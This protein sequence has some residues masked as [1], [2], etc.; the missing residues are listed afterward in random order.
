[1][2]V[3]VDEVV[4][5]R[6]IEAFRTALTRC[7]V[8]KELW[9]LKFPRYGSASIPKNSDIGRELLAQYPEIERPAREGGATLSV[10]SGGYHIDFVLP[11]VWKTA[12]DLA[13]KAIGQL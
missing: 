12:N 6:A 13:K 4:E 3:V 11:I 10:Q 8:A 7:L 2:V 9:S 5:L 1:V